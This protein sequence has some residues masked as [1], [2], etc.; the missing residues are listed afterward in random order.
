LTARGSPPLN[1]YNRLWERRTRRSRI[2]TPI[3]R[4]SSPRTGTSLRSSLR[5][6]P[7]ITGRFV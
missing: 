3:P 5:T 6:R 7:V 4:R 2:T 1:F